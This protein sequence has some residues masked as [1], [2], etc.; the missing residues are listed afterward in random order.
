MV[1]CARPERAAWL[2]GALGALTIRFRLPFARM[3]V[4]SS[5]GT[6]RSPVVACRADSAALP[7]L[8]ITIN[9][10]EGVEAIFSVHISYQD[11]TSIIG[12]STG[13]LFDGCG[14]LKAVIHVADAQELQPN[15]ST[16]CP[17]DPIVVTAPTI[18]RL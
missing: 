12:P 3:D 7:I 10:L 13:P 5:Y 16:R 8:G 9:V 4:I 17:N 14:F 1:A 6:E 2:H 11:P 18:I 15:T